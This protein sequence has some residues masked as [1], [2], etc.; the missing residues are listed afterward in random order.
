[1]T[2]SEIKYKFISPLIKY[3]LK[4]TVTLLLLSIIIWGYFIILG[5]TQIGHF[6]KY[7]DPE[8]ISI[9]GIDRKALIL[10]TLIMFYGIITLVICHLIN[11]ILKLKTINKKLIFISLSVTGINLAI[12]YSSAFAWALD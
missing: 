3:I 6:P 5:A 8:I 11:A 12:I 2:N 10:G 9:N 4:F 7:G 1:M